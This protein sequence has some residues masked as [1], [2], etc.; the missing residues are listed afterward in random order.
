MGN[1]NAQPKS[2]VNGHN[3]GQNGAGKAV[4][5]FAESQFK[6]KRLPVKNPHPIVS[7]FVKGCKSFKILL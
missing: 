4:I 1:L 2:K 5:D 7:A 6:R 3:S